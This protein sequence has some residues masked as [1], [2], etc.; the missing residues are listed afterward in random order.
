MR[1][2]LPKGDLRMGILRFAH[3]GAARIM[4]GEIVNGRYQQLG[5]YNIGQLGSK[6]CEALVNR[7]QAFPLKGMLAA[8]Y[9]TQ[10][11]YDSLKH[12]EGYLDPEQVTFVNV[13]KVVDQADYDANRDVIL[14]EQMTLSPEAWNKGSGKVPVTLGTLYLATGYRVTPNGVKYAD[15]PWTLDKVFAD[16]AKSLVNRG[17]LNFEMGRAMQ[18]APG[19]MDH[20]VSALLIAIANEIAVLRANF[21]TARVFIHSYKAANTLAYQK[22]IP[23]LK[24]VAVDPTNP[25]NVILA[26]SLAGVYSPENPWNF[27]GSLQLLRGVNPQALD[28][29]KAMNFLNGV[30]MQGVG[31]FDY[32]DRQGYLVPSPIRLIDNS[33]GREIT[34]MNMIEALRLPSDSEKGAVMHLLESRIRLF[35]D[36]GIGLQFVDPLVS[37]GAFLKEN[38]PDAVIVA[39]LNSGESKRDPNY[40]LRVLFGSV[41]NYRVM[42]ESGH[43]PGDAGIRRTK[44]VVATSE[45]AVMERLRALAPSMIREPYWTRDWALS[46]SREGLSL[47]Y[48]QRRVG[49]YGFSFRDVERLADRHPEIFEDVR[50]RGPMRQG[51]YNA[52][53][54][55]NWITGF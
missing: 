48:E 12:S 27:L 10:E 38:A 15:M 8:K 4:H 6:R 34:A 53:S 26:S 46:P 41:M 43:E 54:F 22:R 24:V 51:F 20:A 2:R 40:E 47:N 44:Y 52:I 32:V 16:Q 25:E 45:T 7:L 50:T 5:S 9:I 17:A 18:V 14:P 28:T 3:G 55:R 21:D 23:S 29:L 49:F 42:L 1:L 37:D 33:S 30:R 13:Y 36:G 11:T 35:D 39:N 19:M 31:D